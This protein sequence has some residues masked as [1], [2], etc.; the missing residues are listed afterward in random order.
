MLKWLRMK[1]IIINICFNSLFISFRL[2][3]IYFFNKKDIY[4]FK[5]KEL[6]KIKIPNK[7]NIIIERKKQKEKKNE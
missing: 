2:F 3:I 1:I 5:L 7:N 6:I 4:I